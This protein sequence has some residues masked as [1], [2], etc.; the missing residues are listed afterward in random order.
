MLPISNFFKY[1]D[2]F[3]QKVE[4]YFRGKAEHKSCHGGFCTV[5]VYCFLIV[6]IYFVSKKINRL[7]NDEV[8]IIRGAVPEDHAGAKMDINELG[9]VSALWSES[10]AKFLPYDDEAKKYIH[11]KF[12]QSHQQ[13]EHSKDKKWHPSND[14]HKEIEAKE[15]ETEDFPGVKEEVF[16]H[17]KFG[18]DAHV[19]CPDF[20][21]EEGE[22]GDTKAS[23]E[24]GEK[25]EGPIHLRQNPLD[26]SHDVFRMIIYKC[27]P[28]AGVTCAGSAQID[29][30]VNDLFVTALHIGEFLDWRKR[31]IEVRPTTAFR[32]VIE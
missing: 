14:V 31:G 2:E 4:I 5:L 3:G 15:C 9:V 29:A 23:E 21:K 24:E 12:L 32:D 30:Y 17:I 19:I 26:L 8:K 10:Q 28:A 18:L 6:Y 16:K 1:F 7:I 22:D 20:P 27:K 11:I 13:R 25:E